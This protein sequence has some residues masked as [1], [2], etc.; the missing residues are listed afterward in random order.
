MSIKPRYWELIISGKKKWEFR[1]FNNIP[2]N[3]ICMIVFYASAPVSRIVGFSQVTDMT[4]GYLVD[5]WDETKRDAGISVYEFEDYYKGH[6][7]GFAMRLGESHEFSAHL[8][9]FNPPMSWQ[10]MPDDVFSVLSSY[11]SQYIQDWTI[12]RSNSSYSGL[13]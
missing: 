4:V 2:R 10:Y 6:Y 9:L 8:P 11:L 1:K 3:S 5:L 7:R 13:L 12:V